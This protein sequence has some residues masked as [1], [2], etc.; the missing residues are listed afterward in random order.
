[1]RWDGFTFHLGMFH[2]LR[3]R[4]TLH[5]SRLIQRS[6][7]ITKADPRAIHGHPTNNHPSVNRTPSPAEILVLVRRT[8]HFGSSQPLS[9]FI[10]ASKPLM[11]DSKRSLSRYV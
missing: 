3:V 5:Y 1:M 8:A 10:A 4:S 6:R 2:L 7:T 9:T 11:S